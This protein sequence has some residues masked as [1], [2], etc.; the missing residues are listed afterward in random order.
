MIKFG[1]W[2]VW[3]GKQF[4]DV[5]HLQ[6]HQKVGRLG[7]WIPGLYLWIYHRIKPL[8]VLGWWNWKVVMYMGWALLEGKAFHWEHVDWPGTNPA[9]LSLHWL[10]HL[11]FLVSSACRRTSCEPRFLSSVQTLVHVNTCHKQRSLT[12]HHSCRVHGAIHALRKK[13]IQVRLTGYS[14]WPLL[15]PHI[16]LKWRKEI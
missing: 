15:L 6:K 5:L 10:F 16:P 1:G 13:I 14:Y 12:P 4:S 2:I 11:Q 9:L 8:Y 3:R 7:D